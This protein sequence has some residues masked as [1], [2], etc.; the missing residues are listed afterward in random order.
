MK[1]YDDDEDEYDDE[2]EM[3]EEESTPRHV[4][5]SKASSEPAEEA[6]PAASASSRRSAEPAEKERPARARRNNVVPMKS[7]GTMEV[8]MV[9]PSTLEDAREV[10][11]ILLSGR[12]VVIN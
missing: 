6:K 10:C 2:Y 11:D 7:H 12:A 5:R 9:K 4:R 3:E 8:C 1:L